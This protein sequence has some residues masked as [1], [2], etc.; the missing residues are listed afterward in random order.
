MAGT[1]TTLRLRGSLCH[2]IGEF[3]SGAVPAFLER[4]V[5]NQEQTQITNAALSYTFPLLRNRCALDKPCIAPPGSSVKG[6]H[7]QDQSALSILIHA[8][9]L[10]CGFD[11]DGTITQHLREGAYEKDMLARN[12]SAA[13]PTPP[14]TPLSA[15]WL[16]PALTRAAPTLVTAFFDTGRG[17]WS[18]SQRPLSRYFANIRRTMTLQN[19]M[20]IFTEPRFEPEFRAARADAGLAN[21]TII[22]SMELRD[23]ASARFAPDMARVMALASYT[24]GNPRAHYPEYSRPLYNVVVWAKSDLVARAAHMNPFHTSH[25]IW[26]DAG[27]HDDILTNDFLHKAFPPSAERMARFLDL[28]AVYIPTLRPADAASLAMGIVQFTKAHEQLLVAGMWGATPRAAALFNASCFAM[29]EQW[30]TAD[31]VDSEQTA[32]TY[33]AVKQPDLVKTYSIDGSFDR[34]CTNF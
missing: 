21:V 25:F 15:A 12:K 28:D 31:H 16:L 26:I 5:V 30:I 19:P 7:R 14:V 29:Y 8:A 10:N 17:N 33:L 6:G 18:Y 34:I 32:Y 24:A 4:S 3:V 27:L 22:I 23:L 13:Q 11:L 2:G 9:G 20:V 1:V